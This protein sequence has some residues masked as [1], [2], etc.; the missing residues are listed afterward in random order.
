MAI[1]QASGAA[2]YGNAAFANPIGIKRGLTQLKIRASLWA[3]CRFSL[4]YE[5]A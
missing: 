5:N 1:I 4:K 2:T 3:C